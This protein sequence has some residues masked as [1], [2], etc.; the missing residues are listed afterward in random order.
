MI[1]IC[2]LVAIT[3]LFTG[4]SCVTIF[5]WISPVE[6]ECGGT[7]GT[8]PPPPLSPKI[9]DF[10]IPSVAKSGPQSGLHLPGRTS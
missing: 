5:T 9:L 4:Y 6:G 1:V 7:N 2:N 3:F 8:N 10:M